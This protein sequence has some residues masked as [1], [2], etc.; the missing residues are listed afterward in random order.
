MA[1][2]R[3]KGCCKLYNIN[4]NC[5]EACSYHPGQ[6]VFGGMEKHWR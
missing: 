4:E 1:K 6:P 5:D 3:N 2:C